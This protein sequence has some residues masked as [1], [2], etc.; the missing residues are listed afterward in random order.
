MMR[1]PRLTVSV[2]LLAVIV[3]A[4][5]MAQSAALNAK[6]RRAAAEIRA[7]ALLPPHGAR[8]RPLPLIGHWNTGGS[9]GQGWTP[10]YELQLL[11]RGVHLLPWMNWPRGDVGANAEAAERFDAYYR[12]LLDYCRT[13]RL[14]ISLRG[15]QWEAMLVKKEYRQR[16]VNQSPAVVSPD[17]KVVA[18]LSPFGAIAP[19]RDPARGYVDTPAMKRLQRLYPQ[20]PLVLLISNNEAPRLRWHQVETLS[21]R[22][23]DQYGKGHSDEFKRDVVARGWMK[24]SRCHATFPGALGKVDNSIWDACPLGRKTDQ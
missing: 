19:W 1:H 21:K 3:G 24:Q 14:P 10:E 11:G 5:A 18:K 4:H 22:Y 23:L 16:A 12:P 2:V 15:T 6:A 7:E 17:G 8:G 9:R 20:P 13:L